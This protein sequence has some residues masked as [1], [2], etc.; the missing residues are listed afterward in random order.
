MNTVLY[1]VVQTTCAT[2]LLAALVHLVSRRFRER[3]GVQQRIAERMC[4]RRRRGPRRQRPPPDDRQRD[5]PGR[6][7]EGLDRTRNV[8]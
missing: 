8:G 7:D 1:W 3:P 2:A 5:E 6:C 4:N